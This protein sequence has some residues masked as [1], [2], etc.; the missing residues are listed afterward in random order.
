MLFVAISA[1]AVATFCPRTPICLLSFSRAWD[2]LPFLFSSGAAGECFVLSGRFCL[3]CGNVFPFVPCFA[4]N[5]GTSCLLWQGMR[6]LFGLAPIFPQHF[7]V[8]SHFGR[9]L[10]D[11]WRCQRLFCSQHEDAFALRPQLCPTTGM[12]YPSAVIFGAI[13]G[14]FLRFRGYFG[15]GEGRAEPVAAGACGL[16]E[17]GAA[18]RG[19][20]CTPLCH[21][22]CWWLGC[23]L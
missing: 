7:C 18:P 17:E 20:F 2:V 23:W 22:G 11:V 14:L 4:P 16:A 1:P 10:E 6:T 12:L 21:R 8:R 5:R 19:G 13:L 9:Q 15:A 3:E